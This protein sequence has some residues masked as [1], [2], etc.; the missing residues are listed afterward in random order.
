MSR[1]DRPFSSSFNVFQDNDE[2]RIRVKTAGDL[3]INVFSVSQ[4]GRVVQLLPNP[5]VQLE[6]IS[7]GQD[8]IF[9]DEAMR[10]AGFKLR[11]HTPKNL[12]KAYETIMI[13]ATKEKKEF[14]SAESENA[15]LS[16]LMRELSLLEPSFWVDAVIGYE[17]RR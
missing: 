9:P 14:L 13:I 5:Y 15:T 10:A 16:D 4:D 1:V 17:V 3:N 2:I 6:K 12:S 11:V 8:L 7:S